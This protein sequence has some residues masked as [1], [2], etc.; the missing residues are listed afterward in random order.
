VAEQRV[1]KGA[2]V[3]RAYRRTARDCV[4]ARTGIGAFFSA[5]E[6]GPGSVV[7]CPAYVGWSPREG[8]G[9]MD[10]LRAAGYVTRFYRVS[11]SLDIDI[12]HLDQELTRGDVAGL[13]VVPFF[14]RVPTGYGEAI[15]LGLRY[16]ARVLEDEAHALLTDLVG[17]LT[18]RAGHG[19]VFSLHKFLPVVDGGLLL[20]NEQLASDDL[21]HARSGPPDLSAS[22]QGALTLASYD[23]Q[24]IAEVRRANAA[25]LAE[26]LEALEGD[27]EPLWTDFQAGEVLQSF[28]TIVRHVDRDQTYERMNQAGFG[29]TSLYH[30]LV[31]EISREEFPDSHWLSQRILNLPVHQDATPES[32]QK[33]VLQLQSVIVE[34]S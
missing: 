32:L 1:A 6:L 8:S 13:I 10:P 5:G 11:K 18:G 4:R 28:P 27:I 14:G 31:D 12:D 30:T 2:S 7:L 20:L 26:L 3:V 34:L 21:R 15:Q 16:G 17:G 33:L 23:L 29:V 19:A 25:V 22:D 24:A 9:I